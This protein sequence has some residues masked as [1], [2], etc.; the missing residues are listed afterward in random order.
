MSDSWWKWNRTLVTFTPYDL[1]ARLKHL[2]LLI[3][4]LI[5][6]CVDFSER[7]VSLIQTLRLYSGSWLVMRWCWRAPGPPVKPWNDDILKLK[8]SR[9]KN[10]PKKWLEMRRGGNNRKYILFQILAKVWKHRTCFIFFPRWNP[11]WNV[12]WPRRDPRW[13][14]RELIVSE[15]SGKPCRWILPQEASPPQNGYSSIMYHSHHISLTSIPTSSWLHKKKAHTHIRNNPQIKRPV[16]FFRIL[17]ILNVYP[18]I[19]DISKVGRPLLRESHSK[20]APE[21]PWTLRDWH[22]PDDTDWFVL[23]WVKVPRRVTKLLHKMDKM[24]C[25]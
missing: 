1:V 20:V 2:I 9:T 16:T 6:C 17:R 14:T 10:A 12:S 19:P 15:E 24:G 3:F 25:W 21:T 5:C 8:S 11:H 22:F 18:Q 7:D 13:G 4:A 23:E